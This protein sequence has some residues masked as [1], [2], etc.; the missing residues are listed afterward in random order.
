MNEEKDETVKVNVYDEVEIHPNCTVRILKN[1]ET[2][3]ISIGW[4]ENEQRR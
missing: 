4:W 1:T 2:G 3:E